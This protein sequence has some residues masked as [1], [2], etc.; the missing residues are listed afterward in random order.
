MRTQ[1]TYRLPALTI[2]LAL[3]FLTFNLAACKPGAA[4][5]AEPT[6]PGN[7]VIAEVLGGVQGNNLHEYIEL[8][9]PLSDRVDLTGWTLY[10]R[11]NDAEESIPLYSWLTSASIGPR[12]SML[13]IH[14]GL[15]QGISADATFEQGLNLTGGGLRLVDAAGNIID[16]VG[17]GSGPDEFREGASAP[18]LQNGLSL[19]RLPG[20]EAGNGMDTDDNAADFTLQEHPAPRNTG[21][22]SLPDDGA[23]FR[24]A[25]TIPASIAP[26][27]AFPIVLQLNND[28]DQPIEGLDLQLPVPSEFE[29][30]QK[31]G[32]MQVDGARLFTSLPSLAGKSSHSWT[33][34][35]RAPWT[36]LSLPLRDVFVHDAA[37]RYAYASPAWLEIQEGVIPISVA[38]DLIDTT[39]KVEGLA[40]MYTGGYFAGSGNVKFYLEDDSGGVQVWVPSGEG[41]LSVE[42]GDRVQVTGEMQLYR[43]ARELVAAPETVSILDQDLEPA[44]RGVTIQQAGLD[45]ESLPGRLVSVTG[46][47]SRIEEFSYSY[48]VDLTDESGNLLT[49]YIDKLTEM[50]VE[51][52]ELGR[53]YRAS[54]ILEVLDST[55]LLYP[56]IAA[57]L[58]E[59]FPEEILLSTHAPL[60]TQAGVPF[61][62]L[63]EATNHTQSESYN[64]NLFLSWPQ[65]GL[66]LVEIGDGG[67]IED[68]AIHWLLPSL[69]P[70]GGSASVSIRVTATPG[71]SARLAD[72]YLLSP[73]GGLVS[74]GV[75]FQIFLGDEVPIWA[76]QGANEASPYKLETLTTSGIVIGVFPD[77]GGLWIQS[78]NPDGDPSTSDGLFIACGETL[79]SVE[80]GDLI[81]AAGVVREIAAQTQLAVDDCGQLQRLA[82]GLPLPDAQ[83]LDP[84]AGDDASR[85]YFEALEGML[86]A[87]DEPALVIGPS[88]RYGETFVL[89]EKWGIQR[90]YRGD[91]TGAVI[92]IDDG[93][94]AVF[95]DRTGMT[96]AL[97]VGDQV[98][99]ALGPLAYTFGTYKI[100]PIQVPVST[101]QPL[102][103]LPQGPSPAGNQFSLMTWNVENLFDILAPH[104]SSP[105]RPRKAEYEQHL[106]KIARTILAA[107]APS[108]IALQ[109]V[110]NLGILQDLTE[111]ELLRSFTYQAYLLEGTDS[112]GIDVGYLVRQD[113]LEVLDLRQLPAPEGLTSRPPLALHVRFNTAGQ[114]LVLFNNHFLSL[115]AGEAATLPRR[116]AQAAWNA[117]LVEAQMEAEPGAW[118]GVLGDLNS[119]FED[120]PIASLRAA[121]LRHVFD[122]LPAQE[123]YT[124]VFQGVSQTLDHIL[125]SEGMW[126]ALV[127]VVVLHMDADYPPPIP[128]DPAPWRK[129]D[130]DPVIALFNLVP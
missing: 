35:V 95:E 19:E 48:E 109:E 121:G 77:L 101:S 11:L 89:L 70:A 51:R 58:V 98:T 36:Y 93:S 120:A 6:T 127:E 90:L 4:T 105:P 18:A 25:L 28:S 62:I 68:G 106:E 83:A 15:D 122:A 114:E 59:I 91:P 52:L 37:G 79:P 60:T 115:S 12:G 76:I 43:G 104:P 16:Q 27:D 50:S 118:V 17:W 29:I 88:S 110:E 85:N 7:V 116:T 20:G 100:E 38:R 125:I 1:Q 54:G 78:R 74:E 63:I 112:R 75:P 117:S 31:P 33:I 42:I 9:N 56:R 23:P 128:G 10:Y 69:Q 123:R 97:A 47:A 84:P 34:Q 8:Y 102:P 24:L 124:Y 26:G 72:Y 108:I 129:S 65:P 21:S 49:L 103:E 67:T 80:N 87:V 66:T 5:P 73:A 32:G 41:S 71:Q 44:P 119:F 61:D 86:V 111:L 55:P 14:A 96:S 64:L 99:S 113:L 94:E 3:A 130:H 40:T 53:E 82:S 39:V 92:T 45:T 107:G 2:A 81:Q 57:D 126:D 13:L 46:T 22:G 30:M